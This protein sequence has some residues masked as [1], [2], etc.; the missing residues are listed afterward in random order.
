[1]STRVFAGALVVVVTR[2]TR[3]TLL[4]H[5]SGFGRDYAGDWAW[6]PPTGRREQGE[7]AAECAVR[8]LRE[9]TGISAEP[10][11][12]AFGPAAFPVFLLEVDE[13]PCVRLDFDNEHDAYRWVAFDEVPGLV[14]PAA[15][16][17]PVLACL[18]SV[19]ARWNT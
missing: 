15:V 17:E 10:L 3:F 19:S 18:A 16:R 9:E 2:A 5:R 14:A 6:T 11:P 7:S 8:E 1:M 12:T 13:T 4:L